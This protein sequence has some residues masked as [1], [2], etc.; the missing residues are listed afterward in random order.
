MRRLVLFATLAVGCSKSPDGDATPG[1][2]SIAPKVAKDSKPPVKDLAADKKGFEA[3]VLGKTTREITDQLGAP[4][5]VMNG[6]NLAWVYPTANS[7][8]VILV[9]RDD[10]VVEVQW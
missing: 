6:G 1:S 9:F 8:G 4:K 5:Q 3:S 7:S 10:H 2:P